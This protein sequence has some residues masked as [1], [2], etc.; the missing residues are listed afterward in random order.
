MCNPLAHKGAYQLAFHSERLENLGSPPLRREFGQKELFMNRREFSKLSLGLPG[1]AVVP[2]FAE[3][4]S[5]ARVTR[6]A[7][8][9]DPPTP[10]LSGS[11]REY[12]FD[13]NW[14]DKLD[15]HVKPLADYAQLSAPQQ[16]Q[17]LLDINSDALMVFC[18]SISGYMFYDSKVG[19]RHPTLKYD[20]LKEMIRLGQERGIAMELYVPTMWADY[21]IQQHPDWGM[22]NPDGTVFTAAY[23]GYHPDPNSPAADWYVEVIRELVPDYGGDAFFADG[24]T[25]IKYGQSEHTV[26]KFKQEMDREYPTSLAKDPDWRATLRW[27][28]RQIDNWWQKLRNA[29][30]ERDPRVEVTFNGPGPD[31]A[32]PGRIGWSGFVPE[33]PHLDPQTDYAFTEAGSAGEHADW[34]RGISYPRPF[35]VTFNNPFSILDPFDPDE[36]RARIGRTLGIG[37][38]P[39]RYDRTSVNGEPDHYFR[40]HW[41]TIFEEVKEKL[42]YVEGAEPLKYVG[43][44]SSEPTMYYRG[45]SDQSCH[46]DDMLGALKLLDALHIQHEVI[47]DWNLKSAFLKPYALLILP[48]TACM[49]DEQ[50]AA[51]RQYVSEGGSL[52][53]TA[54]ASLFDIDGSPRRDFALAEVFGVHL[55]ETVTDAV[56]TGDTKKPIYLDPSRSSHPVLRSLP[57]T[58]LIL[59]GDSTYALA[60]SGHPTSPLIMDAGTPMNSPGSVTNRAALQ[61]NE[62]GKGRSVYVSGSAF[63]RSAWQMGDAAGVRWVGQLVQETVRYLAPRA[64][65]TLKGSERIWAGLN[66]QPAQRRHVLHLVNWQTDLPARDVEISI[67]E[68]TGAGRKATVVWPRHQLLQTGTQGDARVVTIPEVGPHVMVIF[69]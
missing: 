64:P 5:P 55:D 11:Y 47:A 26:K 13:F 34:T 54:E 27:E 45:R 20:Y 53:A 68:S 25:F 3:A 62:F 67:R 42:P 6:E 58:A 4:E 60:A 69:E 32:M 36:I 38:M 10:R 40:E 21:L 17:D 22:R 48:N 14:V 1:L 59:P 46:A 50:V 7:G 9:T 19:I 35:R 65:W 16:I 41:A 63:A 57:R 18:M 8:K 33:P 28:I 31:V 51:V 44:V 29:V 56:Q 37:G 49:S 23:G 52:L 30:K 24:I 2:N 15:Q 43:V 66:N 39:Y 12:C 61:V